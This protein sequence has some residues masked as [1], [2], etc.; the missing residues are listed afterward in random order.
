MCSSVCQYNEPP[1]APMH[2]VRGHGEEELEKVA[3]GLKVGEVSGPVRTR[4][5]FYVLR[6]LEKNEQRTKA[7][8]EVR[9]DI[10]KTLTSRRMYLEDRRIV[11]DL[12]HKAEVVEKLPF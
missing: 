11:E 7:Y 4:W 10:R 2:L 5:G 12:R 8:A 9:D 1:L 3:F 6:L